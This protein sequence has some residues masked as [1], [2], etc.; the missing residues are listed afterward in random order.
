MA[1]AAS[2][3]LTK[4]RTQLIDTGTTMRWTDAELLGYLSDGQRTVVALAPS[5]ASRGYVLPLVA[6]SR[7]VLAVNVHTLLSVT[8]NTNSAGTVPGRTVRPAL[9]DQIDAVNPDWHSMTPTAAV[10]NYV[11]D[12]SDVAFYV[13]PPNDGTGHLDVVYAQLPV[14]L[15]TL[16][17]TLV[18]Q[19]IYQTPLLDYVLWRAHAKD[20]DFAAG[21]GLAQAYLSAFTAFMGV[22]GDGL[23][24]ANP[25]LQIGPTNPGVE[26]SAK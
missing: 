2:T 4:A 18:V 20:S 11:Y 14:E 10:L 17:D 6:G 3:I 5:T 7:Q 13:Y 26:G 1:V 22:T 12:P 19:D 21:L 15:A 24:K 25:N 23:L 16:A 8:R 9:R